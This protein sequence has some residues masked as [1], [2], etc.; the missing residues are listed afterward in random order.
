MSDPKKL[1]EAVRARRNELGLKQSDLTTLADLSIDRI[2]AIEA[3]RYSS[4]RES[5]L[6]KL[7]AA[8]SWAPGSAAAAL[9]GGEVTEVELPAEPHGQYRITVVTTSHGNGRETLQ[10]S[11][12][13][14]TVADDGTLQIADIGGPVASYAAGY[15]R[16]V[17]REETS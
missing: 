6:T 14:W 11:D 15:W 12:P 13:T 8:L 4:Y 7:D 10:L 16:S 2:Q 5:T 9:A 1:G 17:H 3:A